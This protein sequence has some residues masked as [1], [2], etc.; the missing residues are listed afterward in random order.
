MDQLG[1]CH[2]AVVEGYSIEGHVPA[3][4]IH[5]LLKEPGKLK[6][7]AV[8][9]MPLGSPG[10]EQGPRRAAY[11]VMGFDAAGAV[12]EFKAYPAQ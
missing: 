12:T 5:R 11:S 8:P 7:L 6:G 9:G 2:T 1:S 4:D 10:M 3:E